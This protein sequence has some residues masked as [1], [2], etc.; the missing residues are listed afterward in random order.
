MADNDAQTGIETALNLGNQNLS[1]NFAALIAALGTIFPQVTNIGFG[2]FTLAAS[3]S[4]V[5]LEPL[6]QA[7]SWIGLMPANAAAGTLMGSAK[8]LYVSARTANTS[9]TLTTASGVAGAGT[10][11]FAYIIVSP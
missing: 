1:A 9:F 6:V 5:I 10:E 7:N 4:N 11:S 2:T 8:S 3:A